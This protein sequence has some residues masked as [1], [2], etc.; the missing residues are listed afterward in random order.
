MKK[1][2]RVYQKIFMTARAK[3]EEIMNNQKIEE[4]RKG[5]A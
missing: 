1:K 2:H 4:Q 3:I 5:V